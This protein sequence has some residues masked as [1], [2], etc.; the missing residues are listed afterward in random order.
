MPVGKGGEG[1]VLEEAT[2]F[3]LKHLSSPGQ[4]NTERKLRV[5]SFTSGFGSRGLTKCLFTF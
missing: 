1:L 4:A 3:E 5:S 2:A